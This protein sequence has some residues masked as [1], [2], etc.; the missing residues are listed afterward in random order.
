M[1]ITVTSNATKV[2]ADLDALARKQI[3]FATALAL[4]RV[5]QDVKAE[6][7]G[8]LHSYFV[9]RNGWVQRGIVN[10]PA[11]KSAFPIAAVVATKDE[12][13]ARQAL[14]G[15]KRAVDGKKLGMP[16]GIRPT[17]T[18]ITP[19]SKWP[20]A[21][22]RRKRQGNFL[23]SVK[24][25]RLAGKQVVFRRTGPGK[26]DLSLQYV[27]KGSVEVKARWPFYE[28]AQTTVG[29]TYDWR[30]GQALGKALATR[31]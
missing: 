2:A 13:M 14:G 31:R 6:L 22:L 18:A 8:G 7:R 20:G 23:M 16:V 29:K 28:I 15:T 17:V 21:L 4:T 24:K 1:R 11:R 10:E 19:R 30:F 5:S 27:L 25:G 9:I 26:R 12:F 3:P